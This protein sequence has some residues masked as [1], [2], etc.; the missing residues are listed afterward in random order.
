MIQHRIF[1]EFQLTRDKDTDQFVAPLL[2]RSITCSAITMPSSE[3]SFSFSE[4]SLDKSHDTRLLTVL[5][6]EEEEE[7]GRGGGA[8]FDDPIKCRLATVYLYR[9][10]PYYALSYIWGPPEK[11][12]SI[13]CNGKDM[14]ITLS[15]E[16]AILHLKNPFFQHVF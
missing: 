1:L 15:L 2:N 9:G 11:T 12:R 16:A 7:G 3:E 13:T 5:P 4:V 14:D 8:G 6:E 10:I